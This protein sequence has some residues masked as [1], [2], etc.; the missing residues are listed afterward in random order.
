MTRLGK[1]G[2]RESYVSVRRWVSSR[3]QPVTAQQPEMHLAS[4]PITGFIWLTNVQPQNRLRYKPERSGIEN[5][6]KAVWR[7]FRPLSPDSG[8]FRSREPNSQ[9]EESLFHLPLTVFTDMLLFNIEVNLC[10]G[11][12]LGYLLAI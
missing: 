5:R 4:L 10:C 12:I 8:R 2:N 11:P 1:A 7:S 3:I 9:I 6:G